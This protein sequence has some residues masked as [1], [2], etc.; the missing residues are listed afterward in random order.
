M[1]PVAEGL[2]VALSSTSSRLGR[3]CLSDMALGLPPKACD[4]RVGSGLPFSGGVPWGVL[5]ECAA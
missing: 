2:G 1:V 5:R 3:C 4:T